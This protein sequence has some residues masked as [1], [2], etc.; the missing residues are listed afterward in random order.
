[1][2][3]SGRG[4][5][6]NDTE[7][8]RWNRLAAE[9]GYARSQLILAQRHYYG[10]GVPQAYAEAA[11]WYR[12]AAE[13]AYRSGAHPADSLGSLAVEGGTL[14]PGFDP[15]VRAY[16]VTGAGGL[17]RVRATAEQQL[18]IDIFG[19][20]AAGEA[21]DI[22]SKFSMSGL[23]INGV[24]QGSSSNTTLRLKAGENLVSIVVR[25]GEGRSRAYRLVVCAGSTG[26]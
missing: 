25:A 7:A 23:T 17:L 10:R 18:R 6:Q 12:L 4:V 22:A 1:M 8:V 15:N 19:R 5:E 26:C 2:Y 3:Y 11:R 20:S 14:A 16:T 9:Q 21:L 13:Q 24:P